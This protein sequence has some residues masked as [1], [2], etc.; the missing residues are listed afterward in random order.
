MQTRRGRLVGLLIAT[1][2]AWQALPGT[3]G[4][5]TNLFPDLRMATPRDF[6]IQVYNG[7]RRL[8][9]TTFIRNGGQGPFVIHGR[10]DST[11]DTTMEVR[12]RVY[13]SSGSSWTFL[14]PAVMQ[15]AGSEPGS[16]GHYH[17]HA[18]GIA[19]Y[20]LYANTDGA[21][22]PSTLTGRKTGFCFF[23][24]DPYN[25][26]LPGA[27]RSPVYGQACGTSSSLKVR[28]GLSVGWADEYPASFAW[29]WIDVTKLAPGV[30]YRVCVTVDRDG[31]FR[32]TNEWDNRAWAELSWART[33]TGAWR[34]TVHA[35]SL[36][37]CDASGP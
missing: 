12:Q 11:A 18:M 22:A 29:Q 6:Y 30:H 1:S 17:W 4:A 15:F 37:R 8:R 14:T 21:W 27:P 20:E 36:R 5:A 9:F 31:W 2:F 7:V 10:R 35:T 33:S 34:V 28:M 3:A 32:E 13:D 25:L 19:T 16:D 23:D 24:T 26:S